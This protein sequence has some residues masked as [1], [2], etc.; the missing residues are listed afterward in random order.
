MKHILG[1]QKGSPRVPEP[2]P[3][4]ELVFPPWGHVC[5]GYGL[6]KR[7]HVCT[8]GYVAVSVYVTNHEC[9]CLAL[10]IQD[11]AQVVMCVCAFVPVPTR[12]QMHAG[13]PSLGVE[14]KKEQRNL[15]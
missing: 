9:L 10:C 3:G 2:R 5:G 8:G 7:G 1:P 12:A 6:L 13:R 15:C 14:R 11:F 4:A